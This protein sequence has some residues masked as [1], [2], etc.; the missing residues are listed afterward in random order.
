[1]DVLGQVRHLDHGRRAQLARE[2]RDVGR[3]ALGQRAVV[4]EV[5]RDPLGEVG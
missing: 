5:G 3:V 2:V 1:M 4:G